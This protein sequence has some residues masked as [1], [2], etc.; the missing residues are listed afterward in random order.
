[1]SSHRLVIKDAIRQLI[2]RVLS[3][4]AWFL[5]IK[6]MSPY[7][8]PLRY[9]DY[10]TILKYFAIWSALA[11]FGLYVIAIRTLGKIKES[12]P[13]KLWT[14]YGKFIWARFINIVVVYTVALFIAY[15]LPAYTNNPYLIR[16]LP[17]GMIFSA[18]FMAAGIIQ[19]PLQ[20]FWKMK[21]LSFGLIRAR[22][23]QIIALIIIV[24]R[25]YPQMTFDGSSMSK[26]A[27]LAI[28][29][30]VMISAFTQFI[31]V[32][33]QAHKLLPIK[34]Q[35]SRTF[36]RDEIRSNR[37]YG[38]A[39][40]LSSFHTLAVLILLSN[41][42]PTAQW[43]TYTGIRALALALIEIFLIIPSALGNS[44][45]HK[46]ANSTIEDKRKSFGNFL[47]IIRR[48]GCIIG[49][50]LFIRSSDIIT[51]V[52]GESFI[53]LDRSN[54]WSN[55]ILPFLGIVLALS[56]IKQVYNYLF[57]AT[58]KQ[59]LLLWINL[60]GVIIGL[61]I[62]LWTIPRYGIL[63]GIITQWIL[64]ISFVIGSIYTA[65]R[66]KITP[67]VPRKTITTITIVTIILCLLGYYYIYPNSH[68]IGEM[69]LYGIIIN[70]IIIATSYSYLRKTARWLTTQ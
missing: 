31:Y 18:T 38:L 12:H 13:E 52:W 68:S 19:L 64:E 58:E 65:N 60:I 3:A 5:V 10:S 23:S 51:I 56:F 48:I 54:P 25:A 30:T 29:G 37:Q 8:G 57:V 4:L 21:Q 70:T 55:Q 49:F 24:Y 28:M 14:Q 1:M 11:D 44:L 33:W 32:F 26:I 53:W 40:C 20:L 27:F 63:G 7:L 34:I 16:W 66:Q 47:Q 62:W 46:I 17:I 67:I 59:N 42:F 35:F 36:M 39:Y 45:L 2:G 6:I 61:I 41:Y 50:N 9:G 22:I 15:L 43:Y 69:V